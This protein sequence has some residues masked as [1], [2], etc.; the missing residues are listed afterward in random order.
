MRLKQ[1]VASML[2]AACLCT[3][4]ATN[5]SAETVSTFSLVNS[6]SPLYEIADSAYSELDIVGT[7]AEC[8][9]QAF[10]VNAV[11][12]TVEQTLQK[13]SG[14]FWIW[15]DVD[16]A[17]WTRT[18]NGSSV[19]LSNTKSV[20]ETYYL[21]SGSSITFDFYPL[22]TGT[23]TIAIAWLK[24]N[25]GSGTNHT[26]IYNAPF[27]DFDLYVKDINGN[28]VYS[29]TSSFNSVEMVRFNATTTNKYTVEIKRVTSGTSTEKISLAHVRD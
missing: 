4:F 6:A 7:S 3:C 25:T 9:S 15:N 26:S 13:Y 11:K 8:K 5:A 27:V 22:T 2:T 12:I 16:N 29:S 21:T 1:I 23:K 18:E 20:Q 24:R 10:A 14:W 17:S 28:T 19:R